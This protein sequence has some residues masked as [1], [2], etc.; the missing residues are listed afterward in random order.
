MTR[1]ETISV[2]TIIKSAYP[3]FYQGMSKND[4]EAVINLWSVMFADAD[5]SDVKLALYKIISTSQFPPSVAE[6]RQ[7]VVTTQE[8]AVLDTGEAW[9]QITRAIRNYGYMREAEALESL[10]P[11]VRQSVN[12]MGGWKELCT[13]ENV[14][15]DRA[16]F[17]KIYSQ[18]EK[19]E[20]EQRLIPLPIREKIQLNIEM[21][22]NSQTESISC[23]NKPLIEEKEE[24]RPINIENNIKNVRNMIKSLIFKEV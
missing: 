18:I 2:L 20:N 1:E 9:S 13:S 10:P 12:R 8:G 5:I 24:N 7:A 14:M 22:K 6:L 21:H 4:A 3:K 15:A 11:I 17:I 23:N 19:R 16:H